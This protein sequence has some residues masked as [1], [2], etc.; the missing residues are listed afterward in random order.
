MKIPA[1]KRGLMSDSFAERTGLEPATSAV[2]GR[3]SNQ[4]NY[5]SVVIS[6]AGSQKYKFF[7]F[8]KF[9]LAIFAENSCITLDFKQFPLVKITFYPDVSCN[10]D[11]SQ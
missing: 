9:L 6:L 3:Y 4:L 1:K 10:T 5:H 7:L 11:K 8:G 2:T